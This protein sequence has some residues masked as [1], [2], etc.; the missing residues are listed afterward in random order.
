MFMVSMNAL[1]WLAIA[2]MLAAGAVAATLYSVQPLPFSN[3]VPVNGLNDSDQFATG[4]E[5]AINSSGQVG[6]N[7]SSLNNGQYQAQTFVTTSSGL[8]AIPLPSPAFN[9]NLNPPSGY[10][11]VFGAAMNNLGQVTGEV[12]GFGVPTQ[13]FVG[14]STG[15]QLIP[16]PPGLTGRSRSELMTRARLWVRFS[17]LRAYLASSSA[18]SPERSWFQL[19]RDG[20]LLVRL[21]STTPAKLSVGVAQAADPLFRLSSGRRLQ[22]TLLFLGPQV[23]PGVAS[24]QVTDL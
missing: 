17:A 20:M 19:H 3:E 10:N 2:H 12:F 4:N 18:Q 16:L 14:S 8:A 11:Q 15:S 6:E 21:P 23:R 7:L 22:A 9:G 5:F 24:T 13:G 1:R